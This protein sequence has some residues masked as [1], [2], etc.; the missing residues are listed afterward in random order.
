MER[1]A[2]LC[3]CMAQ[4]W[5]LAHMD[6]VLELRFFHFSLLEFPKNGPLYPFEEPSRDEWGLKLCS[7]GIGDSD[8]S[9]LPCDTK[10][11]ALQHVSSFS[12]FHFPGLSLSIPS[13]G[14]CCL[15]VWGGESA[16]LGLSGGSSCL[17]PYSCCIMLCVNTVM[18]RYLQFAASNFCSSPLLSY[19]IHISRC[20]LLPEL[21][22][23]RVAVG[24]RLETVQ[25]VQ[26]GL[27]WQR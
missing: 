2:H 8:H 1:S 4:N 10:A 17:S 18:S 7:A 21:F 22:Y 3:I 25:G 26:R 20:W 9:H 23:L 19:K 15:W 27:L 16:F 13:N 5:G 14:V 12:E 11:R 6:L 24:T